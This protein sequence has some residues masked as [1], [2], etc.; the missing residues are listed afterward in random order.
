MHGMDGHGGSS[1]TLA[2]FINENTN[3]IV[4]AADFRN[5][6]K[7]IHEEHGYIESVHVLI[8]DAEAIIDAI[9]KRYQPKKLFLGGVSM[10]GGVA[11]RMAINRPFLYN[12]IILLSP[13]L[14]GNY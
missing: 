6:G 5:H 8:K 11:F 10:G 14:R 3:L 4:I 12:G 1:G 9:I 7:N 13:A 2:K